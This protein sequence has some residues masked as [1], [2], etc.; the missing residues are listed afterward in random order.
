MFTLNGIGTTLI[1]KK[2]KDIDGSYITTKWFTFFFLPIIPL[3]SYRVIKTEE[4]NA[5]FLVNSKFRMVKITLQWE[6][7]I[8]TYVIRWGGLILFIV[9]V[10]LFTT[11]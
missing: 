4:S 8:K 5:I 7:I 2:D 3:N 11:R 6:Q 9:I 10:S 1:G